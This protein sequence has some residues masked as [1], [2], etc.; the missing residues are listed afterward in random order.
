MDIRV[1]V[2]PGSKK[3]EIKEINPEVFEV[4]LKAKPARN[5]ANA[6]LIALLSAHFHVPS[7]SINILTGHHS[8]KKRVGICL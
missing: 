8:P 6:A 2:I 7:K 3:N 1:T 4:K 5:Q